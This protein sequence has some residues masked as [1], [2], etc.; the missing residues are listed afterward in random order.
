MP[1]FNG[2]STCGV[3]LNLSDKDI[4]QDF[5]DFAKHFKATK[6]SYF[7]DMEAEEGEEIEEMEKSSSESPEEEAGGDPLSEDESE[8]EEATELVDEFAA[9]PAE[10][11]ITAKTA[12]SALEPPK[13]ASAKSSESD[14]A[15]GW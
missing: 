11:S 9:A 10:A 6:Q 4:E 2:T 8:E 3:L 13:Q 1:V 14:D 12:D 7:D 5:A 15:C